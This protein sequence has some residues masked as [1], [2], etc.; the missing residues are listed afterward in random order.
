MSLAET[1][2]LGS[3][4]SISAL[5]RLLWDA[6]QHGQLIDLPVLDIG[7]GLAYQ[8]QAAGRSLRLSAG[9]RLAGYKVGV[10]SADAQR[11]LG[12]D[13]PVHG[14][15]LDQVLLDDGAVLDGTRLRAPRIEAEIAFVLGSPVSADAVG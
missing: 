7:V 9:H 1:A 2:Q 12:T 6:E 3:D 5:A 15:L 4:S 10:T 13:G 14:Y 11:A 8:V